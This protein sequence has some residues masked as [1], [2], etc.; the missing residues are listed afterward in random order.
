MKK[1]GGTAESFRQKIYVLSGAKKSLA[2]ERVSVI[3]PWLL[4]ARLFLLFF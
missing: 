2:I 3:I 1:A 4:S